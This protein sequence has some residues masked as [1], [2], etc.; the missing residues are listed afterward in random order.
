[1][2]YSNPCQT[3][4]KIKKLIFSQEHWGEGIAF[5]TTA[6]SNDNS[7]DNMMCMC[8]E[9]EK[10]ICHNAFFLGSPSMEREWR[11]GKDRKRTRIFSIHYNLNMYFCTLKTSLITS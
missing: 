1:M 9:K 8:M 11:V 2:R 6:L 7:L 4:L 10:L 3:N 5:K